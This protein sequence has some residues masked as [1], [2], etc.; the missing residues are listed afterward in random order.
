MLTSLVQPQPCANRVPALQS[1][2][3]EACVHLMPILQ[4]LFALDPVAA[5]GSPLI[6]DPVAW[7]HPELFHLGP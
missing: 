2:Q 4:L 3:N 5:T 7:F 1:V 6:V